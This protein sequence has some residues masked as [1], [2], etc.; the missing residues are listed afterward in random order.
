[1]SVRHFAEHAARF[2]WYFEFHRL[3]P[4]IPYQIS[5]SAKDFAD[6]LQSLD[7]ATPPGELANNELLGQRSANAF[8]GTDCKIPKN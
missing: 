3:K 8:C 6:F 1:M 4:V 5:I 7:V 2:W